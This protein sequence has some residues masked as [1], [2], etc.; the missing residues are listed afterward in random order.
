MQ[1]IH[2]MLIIFIL[3]Q[4][5]GIYNTEKDRQQ[6][7]FVR[8]NVNDLTFN[9]WKDF[10]RGIRLMKEKHIRNPLGFYFQ[11]NIHGW[12]EYD[13]SER[14]NYIADAFNWHKCSHEHYF[15]LVWHR[16]YVY[17]FER[18]LRH[19]T[20][21]PRF[22]LPYWD[23]TDPRQREIPEPFRVPNNETLNP[24]YESKRCKNIN[25][26]KPL[27]A[28]ITDPMPALFSKFFAAN[29]S[30]ELNVCHSLGGGRID[31][32]LFSGNREGLL[33]RIPHDR[34][35]IYVGG[36][37]GY[38]ADLCNAARDPVFWINHVMIDR[39]WESWLTMGGQNLMEEQYLNQGF[40]FYN[41]SG[42]LDTYYVRDF[43][44]ITK[45]NYKYDS[46]IK[47]DHKIEVTENENPRLYVS[48]DESKTLDITNKK[49][50]IILKIKQ[51]FKSLF[52]NI[53]KGKVPKNRIRFTLQTVI[54][55]SQS[56][57][58]F[59]LY[60]NLP[61]NT[62]PYEDRPNFLG[63]IANFQ[64]N[65]IPRQNRKAMGITHCFDITNNLFTII[66]NDYNYNG[67]LPKYFNLTIVP[68]SCDDIY[69][70]E[71]DE[72]IIEFDRT[73]L[74]HYYP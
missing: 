58:F 42:I 69:Y 47:I 60:L 71:D 74:I 24:L 31:K 21:N 12:N 73:L 46:L 20:N 17:F 36:P 28:E 63:T 55:G 4:I 45:L 16:M 11:S 61:K 44:D 10:K 32:P 38:M 43:L 66:Q 37:G 30:N 15:F 9:E 3:L 23:Y 22:T 14:A 18:I 59:Q 2:Q 62:M 51:N 13:G 72:F 54:A 27:N 26:G 35:H 65:C 48:V 40:K 1:I 39:I 70:P 29:K 7:I 8:K 68:K 6:E 19:A 34:I 49:R 64:A 53:A 67:V 25:E 5:N 52:E 33:E 56:G 57:L 41:E 50:S